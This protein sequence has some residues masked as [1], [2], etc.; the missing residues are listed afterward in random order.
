MLKKIG[1]KETT[2]GKI[3]NRQIQSLRMLRYRFWQ[4][5]VFHDVMFRCRWSQNNNIGKWAAIKVVLEKA[6]T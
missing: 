6:D 1:R 2:V 3:A 4:S 5:Y